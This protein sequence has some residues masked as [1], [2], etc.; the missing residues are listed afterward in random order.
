MDVRLLV[1][2]RSKLWGK[3]KLVGCNNACMRTYW[4]DKTSNLKKAAF[5][6]QD[7]QVLFEL[8]SMMVS[9]A[10]R[11]KSRELLEKSLN[12]VIK[13]LQ[14]DQA[15]ASRSG[16]LGLRRPKQNLLTSSSTFG[17]CAEIL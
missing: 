5:L 13:R 4:D 14:Y 16:T 12:R 15:G 6:I 17:R 8:C 1:G 11:T 7:W 2:N 3:R 9:T 10:T